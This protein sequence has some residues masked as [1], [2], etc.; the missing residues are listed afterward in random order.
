L[1]DGL[2]KKWILFLSVINC[3]YCS[4]FNFH[5]GVDKEGGNSERL[6]WREKTVNVGNNKKE[7]GIVYNRKGV[8]NS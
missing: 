1:E 3:F 6:D 2:I 5:K 8:Y 7:G 4:F